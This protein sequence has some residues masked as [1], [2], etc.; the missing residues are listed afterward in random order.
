MD[1]T[2]FFKPEPTLQLI[3]RSVVTEQDIKAR[4]DE[5]VE[6]SQGQT[7]MAALVIKPN[8]YLYENKISGYRKAFYYKY[9]DEDNPKFITEIEEKNFNFQRL[10]SQYFNHETG[11]RVKIGGETYYLEDMIIGT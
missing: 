11:R 6:G 1:Y 3:A 4:P 5:F 2:S 9:E 10:L 8:V 7:K